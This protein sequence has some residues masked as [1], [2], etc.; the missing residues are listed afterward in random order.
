MDQSF[1]N[2]AYILAQFGCCYVFSLLVISI[3]YFHIVKVSL[4]GSVLK[5]RGVNCVYA[6]FVLRE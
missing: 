5:T 4:I 2:V 1:T 6:F 3:C